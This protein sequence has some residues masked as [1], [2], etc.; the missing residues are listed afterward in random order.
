MNVFDQNWKAGFFFR[1]FG[2]ASTGYG[3]PTSRLG[4]GSDKRALAQRVFAYIP[5]SMPYRMIV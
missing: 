5:L 3:V 2:L 1:V 4:S